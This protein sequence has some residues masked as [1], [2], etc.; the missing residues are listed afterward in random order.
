MGLFFWVGLGEGVVNSG[1]HKMFQK[2]FCGKFGEMMK[3]PKAKLS[4]LIVVSLRTN[5]PCA[6]RCYKEC[7]GS[8][9]RQEV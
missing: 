9:E 8:G 6:L 5:I 1:G 2:E 7:V 3:Q 4:I